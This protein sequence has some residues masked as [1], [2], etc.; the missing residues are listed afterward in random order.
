M[1]RYNYQYRRLDSQNL[2]VAAFNSNR[3]LLRPPEGVTVAKITT[4]NQGRME[5]IIKWISQY[6]S[7]Q[8]L[9]IALSDML[10]QLAFGAKADKFEQALDDLG[11]ALGF[12]SERPDK[13]WKEG[14]D[15]LWALDAKQYILWECKN[16]VDVNRSEIHKYEAEQMNSSCAWFE[17]HYDGYMAKNIIVHPSNY[18][19][20]ATAFTYDVEVMRVQELKQFVQDVRVFYKSFETQNFHDL[21]PAHI[22]QLI[23]AHNLS[24]PLMLSKYTKKVRNGK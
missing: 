3:R 17:K 7:Y 15:N 16:E 13:S 2:Q 20:S 6:K 24:I 8:E 9:N 19:P 10:E 23:D 5:R 1:A 21:S 18:A 11:R 4:I 22:Q 14:P 12:V